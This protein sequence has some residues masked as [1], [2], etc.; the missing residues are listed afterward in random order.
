MPAARWFDRFGPP[1]ATD[2]EARFAGQRGHVESWFWRCNHPTEPLAFW[3]KA[4]LFAPLDGPAEAEAWAIGFDG[5]QAFGHRDTVAAAAAQTGK[6]QLSVAGCQFGLGQDA[7]IA[8]ACGDLSWQ[9]RVQKADGPQGEALCILPA[10]W[11]LSGG[12]PRSKLLTPLPDARFDGWLQWRGKR[13]DVAGWRGMQ[14][15]NWGK[16][17]AAQYAWGQCL[18]DGAMVE[19]F[20]A[21]V[22]IAGQLTPP[23]SAAVVRAGGRQWRFD[24]LIDLPRQQADVQERRWTLAMRNGQASMRLELD[25][26][27][28]PFACLGYRNPGGQLRYCWNTKLARCALTVQPRGEQEQTWAS[29]R[30]G[31]L[32]L[33]RGEPVAGAEVL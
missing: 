22:R 19:A 27:S 29:D 4:T 31:A 8:G 15:H 5:G 20:T 16:E 21:R 18:F 32:E 3:C 7:E 2:N 6:S 10:R 24:A 17:H 25:G 33:L 26:T 23:I 12:F 30:G 11:L 13:I 9:L 14:G 1:P 28:A